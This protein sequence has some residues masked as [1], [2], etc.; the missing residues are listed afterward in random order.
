MCCP[1]CSFL[2][3]VQVFDEVNDVAWVS[4]FC[5]YSPEDVMNYCVECFSIVN[6][7]EVYICAD[8]TALFRKLFQT[9]YLISC[10]SSRSI[11]CLFFGNLCFQLVLR[12]ISYDIQDNF[13]TVTYELDSSVDA[14]IRG[15]TFFGI[16][17]KTDDGQSVGL[18][19]SFHFPCHMHVMWR[20]W[21]TYLLLFLRS[22][23]GMS[24]KPGDLIFFKSFMACSTSE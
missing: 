2:S 8:F 11:L 21:V 13:T 9:E 24:S 5:H 12:S 19:L 16:V 23:T 6:E 4:H 10:S 14:T 18:F 15:V 3:D 1:Y 20:F 17:T 22:S 7:A